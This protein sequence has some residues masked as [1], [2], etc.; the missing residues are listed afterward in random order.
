[1]NTRCVLIGLVMSGLTLT[2]CAGESALYRAS[3][4]CNKLPSSEARAD[5]EKKHREAMSAWD[6]DRQDKARKSK[7]DLTSP[8]PKR[9]DLCFTRSSTGERVCPN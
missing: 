7:P 4:A 3:D 5:C 9:D 6:K 1:M 8:A 2:A